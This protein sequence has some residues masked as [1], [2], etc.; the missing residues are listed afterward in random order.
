MNKTGVFLLA[1]ILTSIIAGCYGIL[2]DQVT[3][4]ISPQ[5]YTAFKFPQFGLDPA[6]HGGGRLTAIIVGF[7]A[8]WWTGLL[9]GLI[10]GI[11]GF[12]HADGKTM[13]VMVAKSTLITFFIAVLSGIAGY[14]IA[15]SFLSDALNKSDFFGGVK[16][17]KDFITVG[18]IHDFSYMGGFLGLITG[19]I[20][21]F[22]QRK[23]FAKI[24]SA[25]I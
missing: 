20:Y 24:K 14:F 25:Q 15:I 23:K 1:L 19:V 11:T 21:Q 18:I 2:H 22:L 12:I 13:R 8:T 6:T 16:V 4:T 3:Y 5:Y 9:I 10:L 7:R 17:G